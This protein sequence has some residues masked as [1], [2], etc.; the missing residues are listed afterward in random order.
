MKTVVVGSKNPVKLETTK[1]A[2][3]DVFPNETFEFLTCNSDSR[4]SAQPFGT[5]E[6]KRGAKNRAESCR[7]VFKD[8]DF[9]IGHEGGIEII[10]DEYWATAWMCVMNRD[11]RVGYGRASAFQLPPRLVE[12]IKSGK[13]L[14]VAID[15]MTGMENVK[16][17]GGAVS[18]LTHGVID[19]VNFYRQAVV[20]A[21][22]PFIKHEL[23][24]THD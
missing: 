3:A 12:L 22:I 16:Q 7:A 21:L 6:T 11:E 5:E 2:F 20:F 23:Y 8:A 9:F 18:F 17:K 13:E 15:E 19:R 14:G 10:D 24:L 4:V 1:Q